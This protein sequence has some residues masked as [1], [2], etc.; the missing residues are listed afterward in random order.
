[1]KITGGYTPFAFNVFV[2]QCNVT[3]KGY[4]ASFVYGLIEVAFQ[5]A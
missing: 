1:M 5:P 4:R 2:T 3:V